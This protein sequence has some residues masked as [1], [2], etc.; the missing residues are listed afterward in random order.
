MKFYKNS[1]MV[2]HYSFIFIHSICSIKKG[3]CFIW[4][5]WDEGMW[6]VCLPLL[7]WRLK[8]F[9]WCHNFAV[10][11]FW[12]VLSGG[13]NRWRCGITFRYCLFSFLPLSTVEFLYS[14][15]SL[16]FFFSVLRFHPST[17]ALESFFWF[18]RHLLFFSIINP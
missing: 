5:I 9:Y 2:L 16:S 13:K 18:F 1:I 7:M 15:F 12:M 6:C 4:N 14:L 10:E 8:G 17:R 11:I 3:L